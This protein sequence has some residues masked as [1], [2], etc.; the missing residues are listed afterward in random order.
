MNDENWAILDLP[1][2]LEPVCVDLNRPLEE[3]LPKG[4]TY[5]AA[6]KMLEEAKVKQ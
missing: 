3:Q 1:L 6:K 2:P 5:E 4:W